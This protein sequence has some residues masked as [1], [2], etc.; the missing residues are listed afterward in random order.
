MTG[1]GRGDMFEP[2]SPFTAGA[3]SMQS[4]LRSSVNVSEEERIERH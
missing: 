1:E 3:A 4:C 2:D